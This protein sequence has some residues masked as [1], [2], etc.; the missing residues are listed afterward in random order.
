MEEGEKPI[1]RNKPKTKK[2]GEEREGEEKDSRRPAGERTGSCYSRQSAKYLAYLVLSLFFLTVYLVDLGSASKELL[3]IKVKKRECLAYHV[4]SL[5][6]FNRY[7]VD[8]G[9]AK[10]LFSFCNSGS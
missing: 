9:C 10:T 4:L 6:L 1:K 3:R 7:F 8:L 2:Q 5:S